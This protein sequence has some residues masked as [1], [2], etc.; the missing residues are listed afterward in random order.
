MQIINGKWVDQY[1]DPIDERTSWKLVN[2]GKQVQSIYGRDNITYDRL[3]LVHLL[4][5]LTEKDERNLS[6][7]LEEGLLNKVI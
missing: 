4:T 3:K 5:S 1:E 6:R 7:I 2:L